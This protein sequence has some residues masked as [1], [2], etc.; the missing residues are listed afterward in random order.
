MSKIVGIYAIPDTSN[1][2]YPS[3]IHDHNLTIME[4]GKIVSYVHQER[5]SRKKYDA[6]LQNELRNFT[7]AFD[8]FNDDDLHFVFTD[9]E[10]GRSVLSAV[11]DMRFEAPL[12]SE[13]SNGLEDA[14]LFWFGKHYKAFILN[15][16]LAHLYSCV[17]FYGM[18]EPNSLLVHFDGGASKSNFSAWRYHQGEVELL[19]AHYDLKWISSLFNANALVFAIVQAK[20]KHQNAVPGKFM[21]LEAFGTYRTEIEEWLKQHNYFTDC[22]SSKKLFYAAAKKCF[23]VELSQIDNRNQFIQDISATIHEIFIRESLK[24]FN[25]LQNITGAKTLYYSGGSALNIKL[26]S[27][28]VNSGLFER[29]CIPPCTS[30]SG[31]SIGAA[32]ALSI[33]QG[34]EVSMSNPYLNNFKLNSEFEIKPELLEAVAGLVK[35]N[36]VVGICNGFAEAGPRALGNRSIIARAD[37]KKLAE[38]ISREHK[39][40]EW[41][42]PIAPIMLPH[43][44]T[45]FTGKHD[46]PELAVYMLAEFS[47]LDDKLSEI[48]GCVHQDGTSRIQVLEEKSFNPFMYSLLD[49]LDRNHQVKALVNTSFNRQG[50]PIV[51][52]AKEALASA[53]VMELDAVVINGELT[54]L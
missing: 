48:E 31:L 10:I 51:H 26:N 46:F 37:Y 50:E 18:F 32:T 29:V 21:G 4:D 6:T 54:V 23:G 42:R 35:N 9:H 7:R 14:R 52:T 8:L 5:I 34:I 25:R 19:E 47:I 45:Y 49:F 41:Y 28:I 1:A 43:N 30:D 22:W 2:E 33:Q 15:H 39:K 11:G 38:R 20:M 12:N 24:V 53:K 3:L 44:F 13:L 16:E 36:K 40:R 17:P 27:R